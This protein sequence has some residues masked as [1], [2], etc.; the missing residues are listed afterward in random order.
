MRKLHRKLLILALAANVSGCSILTDSMSPTSLLRH[1][2]E[3]N[4]EHDS[5]T[6]GASTEKNKVANPPARTIRFDGHEIV[7]GDAESQVMETGKLLEI[8]EP[9]VKEGRFQSASKIVERH[10]ES[11]ERLLAERWATSADDPVIK[12]TANVLSKRSTNPEASW[13]SLLKYAKEQPN[14]AK[15]YLEL[16]NAFAIEMQTSDP[17]NDKAT[18]LQQAAQKVGHPLV[19]IDSLRLLGLREL[20][21]NR[22]A[23]AESLCRQAVD[24]AN[25]AGN[26]LLASELLLMVAES[27]RRSDQDKLAVEAWTIAVKSHL[28]AIKKEQPIDVSFWLLAEHIRPEAMTWPTELIDSIG[29]HANAIGCSLEGDAETILWTCVAQAQADRGEMQMALVNFKKAETLAEGDDVMWLRIAQS[30]CL[31]GMGQAPA[32]AAI[33]SS[34]ASSS[35]LTIAAA[36]TA[37][38]GS[39]KLQAGAYQQGAQLLHK[40][41]TQSA[42]SAWPAKNQSMADL[43][44]A[45]LIIGDTEPGLAALHAAQN[46]FEKSGEKLLLVQSL[47]NELRLLEHEHRDSEVAAIKSRITQLEKL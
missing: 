47:E 21:A 16:R 10:R 46:Q 39:I 13:T 32:A 28:S 5:A 18:Q 17:S 7:L 30:K 38:M 11:S 26:P 27:A 4:A 20:V 35:N 44:I 14:S 40:A 29:A 2:T 24:V 1:V 33:L 6:A 9:L 37:A 23:W 3:L 34:P 43:A 41:L 42:S 19:R 15:N 22:N 25:K 8:L 31:A 45:Q 36:A 12:L